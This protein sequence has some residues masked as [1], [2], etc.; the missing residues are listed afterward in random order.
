MRGRGFRG[1]RYDLGTSQLTEYDEDNFLGVHVDGYGENGSLGPMECHHPYGFL[2][3]PRDPDSDGRGALVQFWLEGDKGYAIALEDV[4]IASLFPVAKK[5]GSLQ[6][7]ATG[8]FHEIDGTD[9]T[10]TIYVPYSFVGT[11]PSKAHLIQVGLDPNGKPV[12]NILS[13]EGPRVTILE[14]EITIA[15]RAGDIWIR[16]NETEGTISGNWKVT[17][18]LDICSS[19]A[20]PGSESFPVAKA[21]EVITALQAIATCLNS[22]TATGGMINGAA[23][24]TP[25]IQA[26]ITALATTSFKAF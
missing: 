8:S 2:G 7:A 4:R 15:N 20:P 19:I 17:G 12:V 10:H 22:G 18:A 6:Y 3:R 5:G 25:L 14:K 21:Q 26:A 23:A 9:G 24:A 16:I 1:I 13:G 11:V